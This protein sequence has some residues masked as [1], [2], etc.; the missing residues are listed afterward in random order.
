MSV[1]LIWSLET[2]HPPCIIISETVIIDLTDASHDIWED[3]ISP[4]NR[5]RVIQE[6]NRWNIAA[7]AGAN[8]N[9][10]YGFAIDG[11]GQNYWSWLLKNGNSVLD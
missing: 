8:A 3:Y 1:L 2:M 11:E 7:E 5:K 10:A 6:V 4:E 9:Q